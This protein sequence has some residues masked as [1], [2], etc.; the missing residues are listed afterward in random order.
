MSNNYF[1]G[2]GLDPE[3]IEKLGFEVRGYHK[4]LVYPMPS[5]INSS[6]LGKDIFVEP[7]FT[8]D[9]PKEIRERLTL[10]IFP[11]TRETEFLEK[12]IDEIRKRNEDN[13]FVFYDKNNRRCLNTIDDYYLSYDEYFKYFLNKLY[14]FY[15][16]TETGLYN[17]EDMDLYINQKEFAIIMSIFDTG[18]SKIVLNNNKYNF[19]K[20]NSKYRNKDEEDFCKMVT[21]ILTEIMI[22]SFNYYRYGINRDDKE[23]EKVLLEKIEDNYLDHVIESNRKSILTKK[24]LRF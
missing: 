23:K 20:E 8:L 11:I 16:R 19:F 12:H 10:S 4:G 24:K 5:P 1:P 2:W 18:V 14:D 17:K 9:L 21:L 22:D 15:K 13:K 6:S 3:D 7:G